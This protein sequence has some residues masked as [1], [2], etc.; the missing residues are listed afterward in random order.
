[1]PQ[2]NASARRGLYRGAGRT[3]YLDNAATSFPKPQV[4]TE[5]M[6]DAVLRI[7][8]SPGRGGHRLALEAGRTVFGCRAAVA[9]LLMAGQP[10]R[11][12]FTKN[13]TEA[14]NAALFGVLRPGDHV[15]TTDI[16][17]NALWRPLRLLADRG[18]ELTVVAAEEDGTVDPDRFCRAI[19]EGTRLVAL[20]HASNVLGALVDVRPIAQAA[21]RA[22]ALVLVDAAQTLGEQP[23]DVEAMEI[24]LLAAPGHKGLLGPQG[25]G[26]LYVGPRVQAIEPLITGGTGSRSEEAEQPDVLPDRLESGTLNLPGIAGLGAAL[27]YLDD[28]GE[29]LRSRTARRTAEL[30]DGLSQIAGVRILG[31]RENARRAALVAFTLGEADSEDVAAALDRQGIACRGGLHCA[32]QAHRKAGTIATGA[33][34]LSPGPFTSEQDVQEA[35]AAVAAVAREVAP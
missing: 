11:V 32:P 25:T 16:E 15:V 20:T 30:V 5:A 23:V 14:I 19:R 4:V 26:V 12:T 8:A 9:R 31:P 6:Q 1:M 10:D 18:V 21:H 35:L 29:D 3:I 2:R 17:H 7:G 28:T 27:R 24:D 34:R 13:A 22:G 33:V